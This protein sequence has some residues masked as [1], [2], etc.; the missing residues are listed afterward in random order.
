M[1]GKP[2]LIRLWHWGRPIIP[3]PMNPTC[4]L[5]N[6]STPQGVSEAGA[7][8]AISFPAE[9][10]DV[11]VGAVDAEHGGVAEGPEV[12]VFVAAVPDDQVVEE[13]AGALK[14]SGQIAV[15]RVE[16]R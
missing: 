9:D 7:A 10:Q 1:R 14:A 3:S 8:A 16:R 11:F 13:E 12:V 6:S 4:G 15:Q 5:A 2:A